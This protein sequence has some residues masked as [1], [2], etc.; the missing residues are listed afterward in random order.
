MHREAVEVLLGGGVDSRQLI[1]WKSV[2]HNLFIF[3]LFEISK[4]TRLF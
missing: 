2:L 3:S 4:R 1:G